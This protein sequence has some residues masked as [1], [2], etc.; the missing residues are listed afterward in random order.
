MMLAGV[1]GVGRADRLAVE[2]PG[3]GQRLVAH[4]L[5]LHGDVVSPQHRVVP[6]RFVEACRN[7]NKDAQC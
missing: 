6:P 7:L 5:A 1:P 2:A 3:D 4:R